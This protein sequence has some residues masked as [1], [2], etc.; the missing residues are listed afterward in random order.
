MP[1]AGALLHMSSEFANII[2]GELKRDERCKN[3][4]PDSGGYGQ[5]GA[6]DRGP[7]KDML[8]SVVEQ[9]Q[10][11]RP[12]ACWEPDAFD[13]KDAEF[14]GKGFHDSAGRFALVVTRAS[15]IAA[16]ALKI[17]ISPATATTTFCQRQWR[18]TL[19]EPFEHEADGKD[20]MTTM[21][22]PIKRDGKAA[23]VGEW[24]FA[25]IRLTP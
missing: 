15:G 4:R 25:S 3:H 11:F 1:G 5:N 7:V 8:S 21:A 23:G 16:S 14:A 19:M 10:P 13:G 18:E 6:A 2:A 9:T 17:T 24:M 20:L 12:S 22:V